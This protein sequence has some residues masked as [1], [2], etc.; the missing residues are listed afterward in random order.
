M[1]LPS[2]NDHDGA[3]PHGENIMRNRR[4]LT[5]GVALIALGAL[6]ACGNDD[7]GRD[8][9]TASAAGSNNDAGN[10]AVA[11]SEKGPAAADDLPRAADMA[12]VEYYLNKY[13]ECLDLTPGEDYSPS[14][15]DGTAGARRRPRTPPGASRSARSARTATTGP[16]PC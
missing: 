7:D 12:S 11:G 2:T 8:T 13:T 6:G 15:S 10:G 9:G 1:S 16:S 3:G 4:A 14:G 5:I